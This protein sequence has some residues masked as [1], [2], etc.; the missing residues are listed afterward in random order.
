MFEIYPPLK[1]Y[2]LYGRKKLNKLLA[3]NS[4]NIENSA[5]ILSDAP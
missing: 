4:T 1:T 2:K 5:L 3:L